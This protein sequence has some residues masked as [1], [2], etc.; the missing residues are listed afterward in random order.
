MNI[1]VVDACFAIKWFLPEKGSVE[2]RNVFEKLDYFFVPDLFLIEMDS[3]IS[4]K[5]RSKQL[6]VEEGEEIYKKIRT[7][8]LISISYKKIQEDSFFLS[9]RFSISLYDA[10]Y[11]ALAIKY[12]GLLHTADKRLCISH[13]FP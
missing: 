4:K 1:Q 12:N 5:V 9:T 8:R 2:A 11:L 7:L 10:C 3:I 6:S 13:R